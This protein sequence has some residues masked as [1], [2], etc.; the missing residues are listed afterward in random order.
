MRQKAGSCFHKHPI[1]LFFDRERSINFEELK[2]CDI[3]WCLK[4]S[5]LSPIFFLLT[6]LFSL[7]LPV[8]FLFF[9][10]LFLTLSFLL[11][12][13]FTFLTIVHNVSIAQGKTI[14]LYFYCFD[15]KK[16][17]FE[18]DPQDVLFL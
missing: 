4:S 14:T 6:S 2:F 3:S 16:N 10:S 13:L 17:K 15:T 11:F 18:E 9:C 8:Y 7:P 1:N 12:I 5:I